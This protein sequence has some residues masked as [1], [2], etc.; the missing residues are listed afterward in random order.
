MVVTPLLAPRGSGSNREIE[1]VKDVRMEINQSWCDS[2]A[3]RLD[4]LIRLP[5]RDVF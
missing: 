5:L 1:A 2:P 3:R 4:N